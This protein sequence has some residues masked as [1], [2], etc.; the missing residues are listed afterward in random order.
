MIRRLIIFLLIVGCVFAKNNKVNKLK[1]HISIG[2]F[3]HRNTFSILSLAQNIFENKNN[4]V[5]ISTGFIPM[6]ISLATGYK[7][8]NSNKNMLLLLVFIFL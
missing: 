5:Y 6:G 4:E 1:S 3:D 2:L 7:Y 8:Y